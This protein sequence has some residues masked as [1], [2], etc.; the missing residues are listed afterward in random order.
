MDRPL[1]EVHVIRL[2]GCL[3]NFGQLYF[4]NLNFYSDNVTSS[5]AETAKTIE[6]TLG[7]NVQTL[8]DDYKSVLLELA[9][10]DTTYALDAQPINAWVLSF[11][12]KI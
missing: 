9:S 6:D 2:H 4:E 5:T 7:G 12:V 8:P 10:W 3:L 1:P 11:Y